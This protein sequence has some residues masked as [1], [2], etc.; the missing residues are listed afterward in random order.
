MRCKSV[1]KSISLFMVSQLLLLVPCLF[2]L[3]GCASSGVSRGS[4]SAVDRTV[5]SAENIYSDPGSGDVANAYQNTSQTTKGAIL[6]GSAGAITGAMYS[7]KIGF[8]SGAAVGAIVGAGIGAYIDAHT[9]LED[10]LENRGV[11]LVTLG[12]QM[13]IVIPSSRLF[14]SDTA[15]IS[16]EAY[17]TLNMVTQ[18]INRYTKIMVKIAAYTAPLEPK[19]INLALSRE[20]AHNVLRYLQESGMDARVYYAEGYGGTHL[21]EPVTRSADLNDNYRIE[22]TLEKLQA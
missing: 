3:S 4:A 8:F 14:E 22:I 1:I 2:M 9:T 13:L 11:T 16:P 6:G 18:Y 15:N 7:S 10:R 12:D 17:S 5:Q 20:Q 21:V 19:E